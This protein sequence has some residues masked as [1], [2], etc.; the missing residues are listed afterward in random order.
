MSKLN[1]EIAPECTKCSKKI[2]GYT[3]LESGS[4][5]SKGDISICFY[6]ANVMTFTENLDVRPM[7]FEEIDNLEHSV[8]VPVMATVLAIKNR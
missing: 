4:K 8:Y 7:T 5:P 1:R 6:C 3:G 2:N